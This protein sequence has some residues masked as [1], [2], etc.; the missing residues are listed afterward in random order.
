MSEG[1]KAILKVGAAFIAIVLAVTFFSSTIHNMNMPTVTLGKPAFGSIVNQVRGSGQVELMATASLFA[2]VDGIVTLYGKVGDSILAGEPVYA[3]TPYANE[4]ETAAALADATLR[5]QANA[6][7]IQGADAQLASLNRQIRALAADASE[8]DLTGFEPQIESA[9][10]RLA[11]LETERDRLVT[12][13]DATLTESAAQFAENKAKQMA[14]K[15]KEIDAQSFDISQIEAQKEKAVQA[16]TDAI[17]EK[18]ATHNADLAQR[19]LDKTMLETEITRLEAQYKKENA[20]D[21]YSDDARKAKD[22]KLK[23]I[24][25]T[26]D[27]RKLDLQAAN[28]DIARITTLLGG[29]PL[30]TSAFD[31]Q[32]ESMHYRLSVLEGELADIEGENAPASRDNTAL[33][34]KDDEIAAAAFTLTQLQKQHDQA[35]TEREKT[36]AT[37]AS[38][39]QAESL[40]QTWLGVE[41]Q[42]VNLLREKNSL[43]REI[44]RLNSPV[45]ETVVLAEED[46]VI[47]AL[48]AET[49]AYVTTHAKVATTGLIG[50]GYKLV[51]PL[52]KEAEEFV[53][54]DMVARIT[55]PTEPDVDVRGVVVGLK[56]ENN[57]IRAEIRFKRDGLTGGEPAGVRFEESAGY[58]QNVVPLSAVYSYN[59]TDYVYTVVKVESSIGWDYMLQAQSVTVKTRDSQNAALDGIDRETVIVINSDMPI[60]NGMRV[61]L[62]DGSDYVESR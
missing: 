24:R 48:T 47:T 62:A 51:V 21:T 13:H 25:F 40:T 28:T 29:E 50:Q 20:I 32:L 45:T 54:V 36:T 17:T 35:L 30:D 61:Q 2:P 55:L 12:S 3:V 26:I 8:A 41:V 31:N 9:A 57:L 60:G 49:G 4:A 39:L 10:F 59:D 11:Q 42:R 18:D 44:E 53:T 46:I 7:Q 5:L 52:S 16:H 33:I 19:K 14:A 37:D 27:Q 1:K 43:E 23:D 38:A 34:A 22:D 15:Q 58:E 6:L 56:T